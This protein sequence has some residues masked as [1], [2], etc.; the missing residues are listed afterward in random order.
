MKGYLKI[1]VLYFLFWLVYFTFAKFLFLVYNFHLSEELNFLTWLMIVYHGFV[2]DL[3]T[4][5]YI[6]II[7][8]LIIAISPY[9]GNRFLSS[10]IKIY[11][12]TILIIISIIIVSDLE[13]YRNWGFRMDSTPLLYLKTPGEAFASINTFTLIGLVT[14]IAAVVTGFIFLYIRIITRRMK[15][16]EIS[17]WKVSLTFILL[18]A[19]LIFPIRGGT[20]IAPANTGMVYFHTKI[21]PNHAAVNVVFNLTYSLLQIQDD[22]PLHFMDDRKADDIFSE[23]NKGSGHTKKIINTS[24]PN[25]LII[26]LESFTSKIIGVLGGMK[27]VTPNF[28]SLSKEGILFSN[29]FASGDRSDKG[30]VSIISGFPSQPTT[31]IIKFPNKTQR[32]PYL[33]RELGN[34]GY[35]S[36]FYYGGE[37]NFAN[38][39]SYLMNGSFKELINKKD[40]NP[41]D[42]NSKWGVHD[43]IVFKRLSEDIQKSKEPF[44]RVMFTLSSHEP[45]D[46]PIKPVFKGNTEDDLFL[47][48]AYYTDRC[49]G[50][51]I[52]NAKQQSWWKNTLIILVADHGSRLPGNTG[53]WEEKKFRIPMLWLGGALTKNDTVINCYGSQTDIPHT[54]L[55]QLGISHPEFKFSR[56]IL[57]NNAD[58]F[59]F[60]CFNN[61]FG[62]MTGQQK[63]VY[64]NISQKFIIKNGHNPETL[65]G[66][67]QAYL[68]IIEKE[69]N[70]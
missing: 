54:L 70:W 6:M 49:L 32:L 69:F 13:L 16:P 2:L 38:M 39:N 15:F 42:Y 50:E 25:I 52:E 61:G 55:N 7:P 63:I 1:F 3:S 57:G 20:G 47:N 17:G 27:D 37:V 58:C 62:F 60:Y 46:I 43:H 18:T 68:Q 10:F 8:T 51:F 23:I 4:S 33:S 31:S 14:L 21:F 44:F 28:N 59:A 19:L 11:T 64:D 56:D 26:I 22:F 34:L 66:K 30:I 40:F 35:K 67:G 65:L 29:F 48:S 24:R 41:A 53:Q 36:A 12:I 9:T 45:F 5:G